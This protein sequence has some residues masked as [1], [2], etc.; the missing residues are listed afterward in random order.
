MG[1]H[2]KRA[3][4]PLQANMKYNALV[5]LVAAAMAPL[6]AMLGSWLPAMMAVRRD[7]ATVLQEE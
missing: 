5:L 6:I 3:N 2:I 7:P 1:A 4:T